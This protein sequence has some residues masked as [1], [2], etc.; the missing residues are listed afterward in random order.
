MWNCDQDAEKQNSQPSYTV[1]DFELFVDHSNS[2]RGT[3][4]EVSYP[5]T[6]GEDLLA[7]CVRNLPQSDVEVQCGMS[8]LNL[9]PPMS[10]DM[11]PVDESQQ[12]EMMLVLE[13][14]SDPYFTAQSAAHSLSSRDFSPSVLSGDLSA[15]H[16]RGSIVSRDEHELE[17]QQGEPDS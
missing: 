7:S 10:G 11:A 12:T 5:T 2:L 9:T 3:E 8:D 15:T 13:P 17:T 14:S 4:G 1:R 16:F 6:A